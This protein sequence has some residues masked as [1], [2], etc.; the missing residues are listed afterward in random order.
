MT[1]APVVAARN[2]RHDELR[3]AVGYIQAHLLM[4][5]IEIAETKERIADCAAQSEYQ[6]RQVYVEQ[7]NSVPTAFRE[8]IEAIARESVA[9]VVVPSA[10]HLVALGIP[11]AIAH[12]LER[13]TGARLLDASILP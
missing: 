3:V 12:H 13:I 9:A 11:A 6:L 1:V 7:A 4:T 2:A 8:L 10:L 5:E